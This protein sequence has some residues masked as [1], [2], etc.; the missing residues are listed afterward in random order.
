MSKT[1][2]LSYMAGFLSYIHQ[3][4]LNKAVFDRFYEPNCIFNMW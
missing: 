2:W 1:G 3:F 4:T